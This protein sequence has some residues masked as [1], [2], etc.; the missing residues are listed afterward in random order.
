VNAR[1]KSGE[2]PGATALILA[3]VAGHAGVVKQLIAAGADV[4][5]KDSNGSTAMMVAAEN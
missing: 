1:V 5:A 2:I 4:N 3:S